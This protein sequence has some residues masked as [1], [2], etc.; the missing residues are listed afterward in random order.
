LKRF[1]ATDIKAGTVSDQ[2]RR[3]MAWIV[4]VLFTVVAIVLGW[5]WIALAYYAASYPVTRA[6]EAANVVIDGPDA[7]VALGERGF[8]VVDVASGKVLATV[9]P[10]AGSESVD[11]LAVSGR[12]LFVLDARPP[13]HLS[14]F[15]LASDPKLVLTSAPVDVA[16]GPFS[17]VSAGGGRVIVSGGTSLMSLRTY[18]A[19]GKLSPEIA[20]I[21][22][23]RGQPDVLL[24]PDGNQ[25]V[26]ST[27]RWGPYF[28]LTTLRVTDSAPHLTKAG[29]L[30][31]ETYGFT[32][33]G[34]KP[35]N[36]PLETALEGNVLYVATLRG[37]AVVSLAD[38]ARPT[39]L[40]DLDIGVRAVNVDVRDHI[41]AV[42][43]S[44]PKP[45][46]VLVDVKSSS[47]PRV[48]RSIP[49]PE[50]SR[51][52]G[53]AIGLTHVV[54]AAGSHGVLRFPL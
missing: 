28:G 9:P 21:D 46:L 1:P 30:R 24:T 34:T 19:E 2:R 33:G 25:A 45:Q 29:S 6:G 54:V 3:V 14:V 35:A 8:Q 41:A 17:G 52:T 36:F 22:C 51:P 43:G 38:P 27:H 15:S 37:L 48:V 16:V 31:L 26:V 10:P 49:L 32:A 39:R 18:D 23:G 20:A 47:S 44:S 5:P 13:G 11:D 40:A 12:F 42:V 50:G 53:A 4:G 7:F